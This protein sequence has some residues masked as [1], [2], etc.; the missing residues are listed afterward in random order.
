MA[1]IKIIVLFGIILMFLQ[2]IAEL[3]KDIA[4]LSGKDTSWI[5]R[6]EVEDEF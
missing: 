4:I 1:P 5:H 3:I 2:S 6:P